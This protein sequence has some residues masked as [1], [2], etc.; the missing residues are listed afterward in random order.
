MPETI[1]V[2]KSAF[3]QL[4]S[5][6]AIVPQRIHMAIPPQNAMALAMPAYDNAQQALGLKFVGIYPD[7]PARNQPYIQAMMLLLDGQTGEPRAL[8]DGRF[9][10]ALRT[11]A[12]AGAATDL[13]ARKD[14]AV[15]AI[16]G[17]GVQGA[18]QLEAICT[19][20]DIRKVLVFGRTA[21]KTTAFA[22]EMSRRFNVAVIP[23]ENEEQLSEADIICAATNSATPVFSDGH[24]RP[25]THINGVGSY[26]AKMQ[27]VPA[28]TVCRA[29]VFVEN[30][31]SA[32][33]EA[34]DLAIPLAKGLIDENHIRA[35][36]GE[37]VAGQ[38]PGRESDDMITFYKS[39]GNAIQDVAAAALLL[40]S[41]EEKGLGTTINL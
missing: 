4:S 13:L 35:E 14:A 17:P 32:W 39:V 31:E 27:E 34:G 12:A 25:G 11:G 36:V 33:Q 9:I 40:K 1:E 15:A 5:G 19:V 38:H 37:V 16:I 6:E 24:I 2:M 18:T 22:E 30:R 21:A 10:T 26:T 23:A 41:A 28:A 7:N 29:A 20:R 3:R 8:M